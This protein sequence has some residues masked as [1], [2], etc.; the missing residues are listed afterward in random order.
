M[1]SRPVRTAIPLPLQKMHTNQGSVTFT[2]YFGGGDA[3]LSKYV[4]AG[5]AGGI[6]SSI[7][8]GAIWSS[9]VS[10][11]TATYQSVRYLGGQFVAVGA[12]YSG[13]PII[14]VSSGDGSWATRTSDAGS[15]VLYDVAHDGRSTY[16]AAG[17]AVS[18]GGPTIVRSVDNGL[19]WQ[20]V[21]TTGLSYTISDDGYVLVYAFEKWILGTSFGALYTSEDGERWTT[22]VPSIPVQTQGDCTSGAYANGRVIITRINGEATYSD[23]GENFTHYLPGGIAPSY[24][25]ICYAGNDNWIFASQSVLETSY[26]NGMTIHPVGVLDFAGLTPVTQFSPIC[27]F[28][29]LDDYS[30]AYPG[31]PQIIIGGVAGNVLYT[32]TP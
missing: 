5:F 7:D 28:S 17:Q 21:T 22:I 13:G 20:K 2:G 12:V 24:T 9:E 4:L 14:S 11:A 3:S 29:S 6:R 8:G 26:D 10:G 32:T 16:M 19:T 18:P 15:V 25:G 27:I 1:R 31:V 23:D 30:S